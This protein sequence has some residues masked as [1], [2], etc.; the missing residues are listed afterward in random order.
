MKRNAWLVLLFSLPL[1]EAVA[2]QNEPFFEGSAV[3]VA[4][5]IIGAILVILFVL[6]L[7]RRGRTKRSNNKN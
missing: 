6:Y 4:G 2:Q 1:N 5:K 7:L 3:I